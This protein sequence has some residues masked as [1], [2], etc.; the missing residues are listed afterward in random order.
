MKNQETLTGDVRSKAS[1]GRMASHAMKVEDFHS[2]L[3]SYSACRLAGRMAIH[4]MKVEDF[5]SKEARTVQEL[6]IAGLSCSLLLPKGY[7]TGTDRWPVLYING[8]IPVAEIMAALDKAKIPAQFI[9]VAVRPES[10]NDDFTP[11]SAP[12]FRK[13]EMPPQGR[14]KRYLGRLTEE[15]KPYIDANYR[16]QP[17]PEHTAL[18]GH[19]LGG[20]TALYSMY[21]TDRF[22]WI[23][24]LSGSLWYDGFCEFMEE[25]SLLRPEGNVYLSLGKKESQSR[26]P[27]MRRV[28]ECTKRA[29][30]ILE[31]RLTGAGSLGVGSLV[32]FG[33]ICASERYRTGE[34]CLEWNEGGHFHDMAG[35]FARAIAW[36]VQGADPMCYTDSKRAANGIQ[37]DHRIATAQ[38]EDF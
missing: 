7:D 31:E 19:S 21:E 2:K 38:M 34:V 30:E 18:F 9:L 11:W 27:R 33:E 26:D 36:I 28:G 37:T 5:H 14:A 35:R 15:I 13:G 25:K 12:S 6:Q 29:K 22:G 8:E 24:S 3:T 10:W 17:S 16:T 4:A 20:L 32:S 23:G 1:V